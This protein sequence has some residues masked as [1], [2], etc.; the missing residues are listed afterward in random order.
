MYY[1]YALVASN[2]VTECKNVIHLLIGN[3]VG[4]HVSD[5]YKVL[6]A[7]LKEAGK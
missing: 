7:L 3:K 1:T 2:E 5:L 4:I 6:T